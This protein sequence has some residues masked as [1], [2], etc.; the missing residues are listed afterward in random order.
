MQYGFI[1]AAACTPEIK[2]ADCHYNAGQILSLMEK[3]ASDG[4]HVLVFPELC[5]TGYTC[6]DLFLQNVLL[7]CAKK[8]LVELSRQ[9][10]EFSMITIIGIP[11]IYESKLFN[12]AA[13]LY[14]GKIL[15]I[16]PKTEIPN[17]A[18]FYELRHFSPAPT[19]NGTLLI[20]NEEIPFGN[21]LIFR[22]LEMPEFVLGVEICEDLW[23]NQSPSNRHAQAGATFIANLSASDEVIGK[24]EFRRQLVK[25]QSAKLICGYI[26]ADAGKGESSTDLVFS[27]H[28]LIVSNGSILAEAKPFEGAQAVSEID[29]QELVFERRKINT[30]HPISAEN[31]TVIPFSMPLRRTMLTKKI[32]MNPFVPDDSAHLRE[33][34]ELILSIQSAGLRQRM[35]HVQAKSAVVG[36]SGG[37]DSTLALLVS[38]RVMK[39]LGRPM[40]DVVAVTM[41]SFGTTGRTKANAMKLCETLGVTL[42]TIDITDSVRSHFRDLGH[43]ES[44]HSILF[45]NAQARERTQVLMDVCHQCGGIVIG[46]GDLS[47]LALGWATYNGDH[48]SM[49]GVNSS[50]PKTLVRFLVRYCMEIAENERL[51]EVLNDILDTPVSPELLP[52]KNGEMIQYTEDL[53]GPYELHDFF[54]YYTIR[55]GFTPEKIRYLA[56]YAFKNVYD[57]LTI[58]KWMKVFYKR[59]FAQQFKRSCLPDGPKVGTVTLSPRGDW[60]MPSDAS[61]AAWLE[62]IDR[63]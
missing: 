55:R 53:I 61:S 7:D 49:Y 45:E 27:G 12:C 31:Y 18:E 40:T 35:T 60:R 38:V 41:P 25:G 1:K 51:R 44:D 6:G 34:C 43:D 10:K 54:L 22:C 47:E 16:V 14:Q 2:T 9:S 26:Y 62:C 21:Q 11:L 42:R 24:A 58:E 29:L 32:H 63:E 4:V 39:E 50:I 17:Y 28:N 56:E 57:A 36:V 13:V 3:A 20:D 52:P 33:R 19:K 23:V 48:I 30:V 59:F 46:T 37:L 15:G 5:L 8:T